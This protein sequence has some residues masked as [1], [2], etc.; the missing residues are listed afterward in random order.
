MKN[1][2]I[3]GAGLGFRREL[4]EALKAGVPEHIDFFEVAPE[5]WADMGGRSARDLRYFTERHP[6]VCHGLSLSLGGPA[7]LDTHLLRRIRAFMD[8]HQITLF[9]EHLSWCAD[10]HHLYELLPIPFSE[11]AIR[12]T[13]DPNGP[14]C[15][16]A[17]DNC[18]QGVVRAGDA[19]P[20]DHACAPAHSGCRCMIAP[21]D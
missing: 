21:A 20:T 11:K 14:E 12:W 5:N 1:R 13:V 15:A 18:L 6:F 17:E 2:P 19:F 7:P 4:I 3:H 8:M 9:T 10:D 16:D